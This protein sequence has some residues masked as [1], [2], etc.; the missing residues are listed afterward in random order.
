[1]FHL[2]AIIFWLC[3]PQVT[4][5]EP[6]DEKN[7]HDPALSNLAHILERIVLDHPP[8]PSTQKI[9]SSKK[10]AHHMALWMELNQRNEQFLPGKQ[11]KL[12]QALR[13]L[14]FESYTL[15][16]HAKPLAISPYTSALAPLPIQLP[17]AQHSS[18]ITF[19]LSLPP[20]TTG[21][22]LGV[23]LPPSSQVFLDD[24]ALV[25]ESKTPAQVIDNRVVIL[26]PLSRRDNSSSL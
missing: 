12:Y 22:R 4:V 15:N 20:A 3:L 9:L 23:T 19:T 18:S 8:I 10:W 16:R 5:A 24:K 14:P 1:M 17:G 11:T 6:A 21:Q 26:Q 7:K 2:R 25:A 13:L